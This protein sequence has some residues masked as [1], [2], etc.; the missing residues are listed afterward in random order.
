MPDDVGTEPK[1]LTLR[2]SARIVVAGLLCFSTR[3]V[4]GNEC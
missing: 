1:F 2:S 4:N 3:L